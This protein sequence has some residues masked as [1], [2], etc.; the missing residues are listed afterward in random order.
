[1]AAQPGFFDGDE[2]LKAL[3]AAGDPLRRLARVIDFEMFR[4]DLEAALSC[5]D[6]VRGG[7]PAYDAVLMFRVLV[8]QT[9]YTLSDDQTEYQL[10]DRLSFMQF[11]GLALHDPVP[12][13]K[14]I[15]L[16]RE[17]L[18]RTG[19]VEQLFGLCLL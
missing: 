6:R 11:V 12:D 17:Q 2:R 5:S 7:R 18:A 13:A 10:K 8:L 9:L 3:S 15:W 1:M 19:T 16:Y 14:T 4:D